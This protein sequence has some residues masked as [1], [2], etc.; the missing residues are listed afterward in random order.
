VNANQTFMLIIALIAAGL[1]I[2]RHRETIFSHG[3]DRQT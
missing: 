1:I 2:W 3:S